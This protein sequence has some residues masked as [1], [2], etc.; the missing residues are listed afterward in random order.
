MR[1]FLL[2]K[3]NINIMNPDIQSHF[4][5]WFDMDGRLHVT[6]SPEFIKQIKWWKYGEDDSDLVLSFGNIER[7]NDWGDDVHLTIKRKR[8]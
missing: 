3:L 4:D 1:S 2:Y 6:I 8:V 7:M 5:Y